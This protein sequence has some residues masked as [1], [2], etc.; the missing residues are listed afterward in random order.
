MAIDVTKLEIQDEFGNAVTDFSLI[1]VTDK[2]K[3]TYEITVNEYA[4]SDVDNAFI[5]N[6]TPSMDNL[7]TLK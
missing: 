5:L 4:I 6:Y 2:V 7:R 3:L 1:N